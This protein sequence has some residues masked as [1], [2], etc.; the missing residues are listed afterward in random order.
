MFRKN[1]FSFKQSFCASCGMFVIVLASVLLPAA[2]IPTKIMPLGDSITDGLTQ[3][4]CYRYYLDSLLNHAGY[5]HDLVGSLNTTSDG[6]VGSGYDPDHEGH[7]GMA[8][9]QLLP[10]IGGYA[11]SARP[12]IVL[13]HLGT[14]DIAS[15]TP[16]ENITVVADRTILELGAIIDTLR[17]VNPTVT[18]F[19]AQIIPGFSATF[20]T[21]FD[22]LNVRIPALVAS[23]TTNASKVIL[24]DQNTGFNYPADISNDGMHPGAPGAR[25]MGLKWFAALDAFLGGHTTVVRSECL[26]TN[27]TGTPRFSAAANGRDIVIKGAAGAVSV[28]DLRGNRVARL[29]RIGSLIHGWK[30]PFAG[31]F[32]VRAA[33]KS[34]AVKIMVK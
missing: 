33:D 25:K 8:A 34:S 28:Y 6:L 23:K 2:T 19:L 14:N 9:H 21:Y 3:Y 27:A 32:I 1:Q 26:L 18:I 20:V 13:M 22:S 16:T 29:T 10:F 12:D 5:A 31:A 30:A 11:R 4:Q 17:S 15:E 24:V 7:W